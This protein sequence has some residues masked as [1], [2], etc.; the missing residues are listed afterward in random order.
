MKNTFWLLF[1]LSTGFTWAQKGTDIDLTKGNIKDKF[2]VLYTRSGSYKDYKVIKQYLFRQLEKQVLDTLQKQKSTL[3]QV[4]QKTQDLQ[5][6][7]D[8]LQAQLNLSKKKIEDLQKEKNQ[9][10]L[11]GMSIDKDSYQWLVWS[12]I[13]FL[14]LGL[15][16]FIFMFKNSLQTT[17]TAKFNLTKLEEEYNTFRANALE[18]EQLLKRQLLDEQ[19]KHQA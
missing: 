6:K 19:K 9:I 3:T 4:R 14:I 8:Q 11:A 10:S 12:I 2:E 16:Y 17:K 5:D 7:I 18:R 15:S 1:L 13:V